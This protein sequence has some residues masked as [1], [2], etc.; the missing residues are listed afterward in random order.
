[1]WGG[2]C[3]LN[4]YVESG[5]VL[6]I[7][8]NDAFSQGKI[9]ACVRG[10]A[11]RGS[12]LSPKRLKYPLLRVGKRGEGE[13]RRISWSEAI[14]IMAHEMRRIKD[15]YGPASRYVNYGTGNT[16]L[17]K[18]GEQAKRLLA[19]DGGYLNYHNS[20]S[21]ACIAGATPYT[22]GDKYTGNSPDDYVN[23][24]LI[25][26][27]GHNPAA[28]K[29]GTDNMRHLKD[30]KA[31]G[32]KI[33]VVDPRFTETA[34][35]LADM[36]IA[37][38]PT[39]DSAFIDA[40][41]F[42]IF[43]N[44]W[45]D[46]DFMNQFCLGFDSKHMPEG[47]EDC[48]N[49]RDYVY[50][51]YDSVVKT[52]EWA[53]HITGVPVSDILAFAE[54]FATHK[55]AALIQ[56]YGP[57]R[58]AN[59]E[60][61]VRSSNMLTC[62]TGNVG[63][64]GGS[65][66]GGPYLQ[67]QMPAVIPEISNP[68]KASIPCFLWTDA[69]WRAEEM[70]FEKDGI[71]GAEGLESGIKLIFNLAGNMLVNQHSDILKTISILEDPQN[72]EFIVCSDLF[73]TSSALYADLVLPG[74]SMFENPNIKAPWIGGE[75]LLYV[76]QCMEPL[77]ESRFEYD[78][79]V[80]LS[81]VMG[82]KPAFTAGADNLE[83]R[84]S[85]SYEA[86]RYNETEL[87]EF[88]KFKFNG[89]HY[90]KNTQTVIA[91][92]DQIKDLENNP[93]KTSSGKIEI[94][95]PKLYHLGNPI[96]IPAIPKY[97]RAFEGPEDLEFEEYPFQLIGW[98]TKRRTHSTHDGNAFLEKLEPQR[99]WMNPSDAEVLG[100]ENE[101]VVEVFNNRGKLQIRVHIT[102]Q[103]MSGV[104]GMSQGRWLK[105]N[106]DGI[107]VNGSINMLTTSRPTPLVKGNPQHSN[108]VGIRKV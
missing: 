43:E 35:S 8:T 4:A 21:T 37:I 83:K 22:F 93:F 39:T 29:F 5:K 84:L 23:S 31:N 11:Y 33:V 99:L 86:L 18:G 107:D 54:L 6:K 17:I 102:L 38:K 97:V 74:T 60:Q 13:F 51:K 58:N 28:T 9:K 87:P 76:N 52:P 68:I 72:V 103:I 19:L 10:N 15:T 73:M 82:L 1:M 81:E 30:A 45:Q 55:P 49:Y 12:F 34:A 63:I 67:H 59:G 85:D 79:L 98:H 78:W 65:A 70:T 20:Y 106:A 50:G 100:L 89:G 46:Q 27:W 62:L 44:N 77:F 95:S 25:V 48:E 105:L 26:L 40:V 64:S 24:K 92:E 2:A 16:A 69:I 101:D 61:I 71:I 47:Y 7:E 57:Q 108:R 53:S 88:E 3:S 90:Y 42:I 66:G 104:V 91:Y 80:D 32:C 56:G 94:F 96:E 36:W 14:E 41:S 75:Y